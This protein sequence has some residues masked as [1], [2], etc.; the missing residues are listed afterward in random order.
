MLL[1]HLDRGA[2]NQQIAYDKEFAKTSISTAESYRKSAQIDNILRLQKFI[3]ANLS[4][5]RQ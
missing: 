2:A 5:L 1:E 4:D 3:A